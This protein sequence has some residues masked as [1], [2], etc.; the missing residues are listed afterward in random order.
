MVYYQSLLDQR[1]QLGVEQEARFVYESGLQSQ[2]GY[3]IGLPSVRE[4]Y[5]L[6]DVLFMPSHRE[7]FGM[8]ILEAGLLG[9]SIFSTEIPAVQEIGD[10]DV[11]QFSPDASPHKVAELILNWAQ[12]SLT[13][14]LRQ[15]IRQKYTWHAIFQQD[16]LPLL[17]GE[18]VH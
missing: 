3:T 12:A 6:S 14:R 16:I 2:T 8:P 11:I 1:K 15:R 9:M 7:G 10:G 18:E 17:T 13:Q 4:L 5:R